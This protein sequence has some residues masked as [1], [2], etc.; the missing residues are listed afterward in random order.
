MKRGFFTSISLILVLTLLVNMLPMGVFAQELRGSISTETVPDIQETVAATDTKIVA[1]IEEKRTEFSKEFLM[2]NGLH[3]AAVYPEAVHYEKDG[4]WAEIDNTLTAKEDGTYA[5][6]AGVWDVRFPQQLTGSNSVTIEKDGYTL[7]FAMAGELRSTGLEIAAVPEEPEVL[8]ESVLQAVTET[9]PETTAEVLEETIPETTEGTVPETTA[10]TVPETTTALPEETVPETTAETIPETTAETVPETTAAAI[11]ETVPESTQK[12][13]LAEPFAVSQMQLST[14]Q[15]QP[16][17]T[18]ALRESYEHPEMAP[19]KLRSRLRYD[20]VYQNTNIVY[21]LDSNQVKESIVIE[22]YSNTLRGYRYTLNVGQMVPVLGEDGQ[23]TLYAP[24]GETVVMVM[25]APY[26]V[27]SADA[28]NSDIQV[29]LSGSGSRYTL[30]YLLPRQWLAAQDRAWPVVL[31]PIVSADMTRSN[32]RDRTVSSKTTLSQNWGMNSCGWR[33]DDGITRTYLKYRDLPPLKS[34]DVVVAAS[35]QMYR[36]AGSVNATT[37]EVHKVNSTWESETVSWSN[38]PAYNP[39]VEDYAIVNDYSWYEWNITDIVRGWYAGSNTGMLFKAPDGV[40]TGGTKSFKQFFSSDYGTDGSRP[41]L[42]IAFRNNNGLEGYWDYT[43]S[44]AGRA[45]TGYINNFTGNLVWIREDIGFGGNRMPVSIQHIYNANDHTSNRFGIGNGW[46]TNYN[47][48]VYEW[49]E[50]SNYYVW[51]DSDGT[52]HYFLRQSDGSY[53]HEDDPNLVLTTTGSGTQKYCITDKNGNKSYFD[54]C[55]R[56]TKIE[57]NQQKKSSIA[58]SYN[59]TTNQISTIADGVERKY[60][61]KYSNGLLSSLAYRGTGN[62]DITYIT[63][64]YS[65]SYLITI[66]DTDGQTCNYRYN[67]NVLLRYAEDVGGYKV[68]YTYHPLTDADWQPYRVATVSETDGNATGGSLSIQYAH[69]QTTFTDHNG[70]VEIHQFNDFGNTISVQDDEGHAQ[71]SQYARNTDD[72]SGKANQ[73]K[74]SSKLQNTVGNVLKNSSF[75]NG[76]KWSYWPSTV[77]VSNVTTAAYM[78]THSLLFTASEWSCLMSDPFTIEPGATYTF[79]AYVKG[80]SGESYMML[81]NRGDMS[82]QQTTATSGSTDWHRAEVSYTNT[83][84]SNITVCAQ[85]F[86]VAGTQVYMDCAQVEKAETAS[87]YNLVE[88]GDF[89]YGITSWTKSAGCTST[90]TSISATSAAYE[91]DNTVYKFEGDP[92]TQKHLWQRVQVSGEKGDTF[93]LSGWAKGDSVPITENSNREFSLV[94]MIYNT[95]NTIDEIPVSF[96]PDSDS[97]NSW[98]YAAGVVV[99]KK[100][101]SSIGLDIRYD[102]NANTAYFDGIQL[103]KEQFGSSYTYDDKGNVKSVTDLQGQTTTYEYTNNDLTQIIQNGKAKMTYTYDSYHNVKT[104]TTEE[105]LSYS[106]TYDTYGNNTAVSISGTGGTMTSTAT[107]ST[108]GNRLVST[109]DALGKVTTYG[110]NATTNVLEWVQYPN[111]TDGTGETADTRTKYTYDSMYRMASAACT[112]D[113]GLNLSASYTYSNDLLTSIQTPSTT[114]GF[115]Y[116]DFDLRTS[117]SAGSYTLAEYTYTN[118]KNRYLSALDYGNGDSVQ[119][120][121]D[122]HGRLV[123]QTYE[124]GDNLYHKYDNSGN[125]A[126]VWDS[127][128]ARTTYYYYDLTDRMMKYVEKGDDGYSHS[129]GYEYNKLN[130]L[131][132]Q[133][134]TIN[135]VDHTTSYTYDDDNRVETVT[136]GGVTVT[137]TYDDLGR[138]SKQ[139]TRNG[140]T[141]ILTE[142]FTY[143]APE[144]G[145]TSSQIA[146]YDVTSGEYQSGYTYTYD[147][148]GNITKISELVYGTAGTYSLNTFYT[149]DSANQLIKERYPMAGYTYQWVYD[150]AGNILSRTENSTTTISYG[151]DEDNTGWG[152]LLT[153]YNGQAIDSDLLGNITDDGTWEY[154]W[155][156]GRQLASMSDGT[157]TWNYT[158]NADGLRTKKTN[159]TDTYTYIYNGSQLTQMTKGT[160]TLYFTYD[161]SGTPLT[162]THNGTTYYYVTN[163]Q[164]DVVGILNGAGESLVTYRYEAS[165]K[166]LT[167]SGTEK[168][169]L[170]ALNP[171]R[172]RGYV[173]DTETGLYYLQSRYYNPELGRFIGADAFTSTGQGLLGYNMFAYCRNNPSNRRDLFGCADEPANEEELNQNIENIMTLFGV[174]SPEDIPPLP[175]NAMYFLEN[176]TIVTICGIAW[177]HGISIVMDCDKYCMYVFNGI[178]VGVSLLPH[179][180]SVTAGYVYNVNDV[181]DF[182]GAFY[183]ASYNEIYDINGGAIASNGVYTEIISGV[184]YGSA[185]LGTSI[186]YYETTA[187]DWTYGKAP[188][189]WSNSVYNRTNPLNNSTIL[190]AH[191]RGRW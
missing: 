6:T 4:A 183:G 32:I 135:G 51:E 121:Y 71:Y 14:A 81:V 168:D 80:V 48:L 66:T 55:G 23:I 147:G 153:S 148:N 179:D 58:I 103:Y 9:V 92:S 83:T 170:G 54:D 18:Q 165:G 133:V 93:V 26:L 152:D 174:A 142:E 167:L 116:G 53:Q 186:T 45:G 3:M 42:L 173:Y 131:T 20:D 137:Y 185:S 11:E 10:E 43:A 184:G 188:I 50:D 49:L 120:T 115:T 118:D 56:L 110:Y 24:D 190:A 67:T 122:D 117:V 189:N 37:V 162:L 60:Y 143:T 19:D 127:A 68:N 34:S 39:S 182:C 94:A 88:N 85:L 138:V 30:T 102:Y 128:T 87:R 74:L 76:S 95:D 149:Y 132:Q 172:Y 89:R 38:M 107:Y 96:N 106:F 31:D 2:N 13:E 40:E 41:L 97:T 159:G 98:Q 8:A 146:T 5:N 15:L 25:P 72:D 90:E 52:K 166:Q 178:S 104:A 126:S 28:Y 12:A 113:T 100:P 177:V 163:I 109:T 129:V 16:M 101:Y 75:E 29:Q 150:D 140:D 141:L 86:G 136:T 157:T 61:F 99:T 134:E 164:G 151:Y 33:T 175:E 176:T 154:T 111:D 21:D 187:T 17:N 114:Y 144:D 62:L 65:N 59:D 78:G 63:F 180:F 79:S 124:D 47:Q 155:E 22:S 27:D 82:A 160:D 191:R 156:H 169:G 84:N 112:T 57:N 119:Y 130:N 77:S 46:R 64:S 108:D 73:L 91:L 123:T 125:L 69:N 7:S 1:E 161:A 181:S 36:Y 35:I 171:L 145:K 44:S 105:G 139:E 70:N 158:Y